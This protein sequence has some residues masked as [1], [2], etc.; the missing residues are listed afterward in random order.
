[1]LKM[2]TLNQVIY[3]NSGLE[4]ATFMF[5][6]KPTT[7]LML[8]KEQ[9]STI[10]LVSAGD[11]NDYYVNLFIRFNTPVSKTQLVYLS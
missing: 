1:M 11:V 5:E 2:Y 4:L 8:Y 6:I 10:K 7:L 9:S 3:C